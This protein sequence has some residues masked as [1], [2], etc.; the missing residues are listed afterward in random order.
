MQPGK[1]SGECIVCGHLTA[2]RSESGGR[3]HWRCADG[4]DC[5]VRRNRRKKRPRPDIEVRADWR[6]RHP[7]D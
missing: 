2:D 6:R 5:A 7:T 4:E 1:A 3:F